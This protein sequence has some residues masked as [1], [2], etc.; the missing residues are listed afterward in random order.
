MKWRFFTL[1]AVSAAV[2]IAGAVT[3]GFLIVRALS[4]MSSAQ[5]RVVFNTPAERASVQSRGRAVM[6]L[7]KK[8]DSA[9]VF[10]LFDPS[11]AA[12][13]PL[14]ELQQVIGQ[15]GSVGGRLGDT[16]SGSVYTAD[17]RL[18]S[19]HAPLSLEGRGAGGEGSKELSVTID[20]DGDGKIAGLLLRPQDAPPPDPEAGYRTRGNYR[21]PFDGDWTVFW[22]GDTLSQNYHVA[23]R[24]QRHAY[25]IVV[26]RNGSTHKGDGGSLTDYYAFGKTIYAPA[27]ATVVGAV[28]GLPDNIPG[29]MDPDHAAGNH[30]ILSCGNGEYVLMAHFRDHSLRVHA[31]DHVKAGQPIAECGD[32]GNSSEPH[33]HIHLQNGPILFHATGLPLAFSSMI[34]DGKPVAKAELLRGEIVRSAL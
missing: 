9:A 31:G 22:G 19:T 13:V 23:Y 28:D 14:G 7:V 2:A 18:G 20:F 29:V 24:D 26:A 33:L 30:V 12:A 15:V 6:E 4:S 27:D 21:L 10:A 17:Y 32:T 3:L 16:A 25:D 5:N 1:L 11:M 34:V 8:G